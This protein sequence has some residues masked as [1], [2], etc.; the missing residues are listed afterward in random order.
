MSYPSHKEISLAQKSKN[1]SRRTYTFDAVFTP[2]TTQEE[3]F[4]TTVE[5]IVNEALKG[6]NCTIFAY[7][8]T[9]TGKTHTMEGAKDTGDTDV[10]RGEGAGIIPRS[11]RHIFKHLDNQGSE[12]TV[13][14]SFLE[15]YNEELIDLLGNSHDAPLKIYED[16]DHTRKGV[17]VHGLEEL[18]VNSAED[19][20]RILERGLAM[21][22]AAETK[23]NKNS[24]R[25]HCI[26]SV[27]IH[28]RESTPE[29]EDLLKVGKLNLVDLAGAENIGR[30]GATDARRREAMFI[31]QS[32]VTLGR[33][34]TSLVEKNPHIPY[35]ESKLTRLLQESLGGRTKTCII[36]TVTPASSHL[37]ETL[38]T[39]DYA[40]RAKNIRNKPEINQKMTKRALIKD[41][42]QEIDKL[43]N[44]LEA[45]RN[46][47]G[48]YITRDNYDEMSNEIQEKKQA[49][50]E[51]ETQLNAMESSFKEL[52]NLFSNKEEELADTTRQFES[53]KV[54]TYTSN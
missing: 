8:Q 15:L 26:F 7:G 17:T 21:R 3:L 34:I 37:D 45:A 38:S 39:L 33:V 12:Y 22:H 29:G 14:V 18:P 53:T 47:D 42:M 20:F 28:T 41:Y 13:R 11:V 24:S 48:F 4:R 25:S 31:N 36:A 49:V 16:R 27:I 51:L 23:L 46:K 44:N 50:T 2:E 9:G 19:I 1:A 40:L 54:F 10:M 6:F 52:Q 43:R 35:R 30:S 5:P 32:L